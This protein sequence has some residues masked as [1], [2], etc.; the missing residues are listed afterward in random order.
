M[1]T[2]WT[3]TFV[4][5]CLANF[6]T[7]FG[8]Q[9]IVPILPLYLDSWGASSAQVGLI[10]AGFS[11]SVII[12]RP[13]AALWV[14]RGFD[15]LCVLGGT[16][17][18][19][20]AIGGYGLASGLVL[21]AM[22]RL[23]HGAGFGCVSVAY[24]T[25]VA[26]LVPPGRRAEGMGYFGISIGLAL[27]LGPVAGTYAYEY[28]G[29]FHALIF[30]GGL[31]SI[32]LIWLAYLPAGPALSSGKL[33]L[34]WRYFLEVSA[35]YP[36]LL[37]SLFGLS[38]GPIIAFVPLWGKELGISNIGFFFLLN[39]TCTMLV[40]TFSGKLA[41]RRG[42]AWV[43]LPAALV[44]GTGLI[45]L[46][47]AQGHIWLVGAGICMGLGVGAAYPAMQAWAVDLAPLERRS[48]ALAFYY[49]AFDLG[50]G[51]GIVFFGWLA[52][53]CGYS[54]MYGVASL[55]IVLYLLIYG[56]YLLKKKG[57]SRRTA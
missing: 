8:F 35:A 27:C 21:L 50:V 11:L 9:T 26:R 25:F 6:F 39:A 28:L 43:L 33:K 46:M 13:L 12:F 48:A 38:F 3:K 30:A 10:L 31:T 55:S 20:A 14:D 40:R 53:H 51:C 34:N 57:N 54:H 2:M 15:K 19:L 52:S 16:L 5:I 29:F 23:L 37:I 49:N 17:V 45:L 4:F 42:Y 47:L 56:W 1:S 18:C 32:G 7:F 36:C 41:D 24:G 44:H 22:Y